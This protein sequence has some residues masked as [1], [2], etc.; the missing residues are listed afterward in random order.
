V[1]PAVAL[2]VG[3]L[4][5]ARAVSDRAFSDQILSACRAAARGDRP[6]T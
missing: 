4:M 6:L 3:G 5:L 1:I 2:C